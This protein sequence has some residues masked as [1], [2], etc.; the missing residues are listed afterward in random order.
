MESIHFPY[1]WLLC[2]TIREGDLFHYHP[3]Y[4]V[5]QADTVGFAICERQITSYFVICRSEVIGK[6]LPPRLHPVSRICPPL[7]GLRRALPFYE[8]LHFIPED[9]ITFIM[10]FFSTSFLFLF[11]CAQ[12]PKNHWLPFLFSNNTLVPQYS[13]VLKGTWYLTH[14]DMEILSRC[15]SLSTE[16]QLYLQRSTWLMFMKTIYTCVCMRGIHYISALYW[17]NFCLGGE[18]S[19]EY[20]NKVILR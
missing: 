12:I 18:I 2:D 20:Q 6:L 17:R 3:I 4:V 11:I 10:P 1:L 14:F 19:R 5:W 16:V 13:T 15:S 8:K 9:Q 7:L